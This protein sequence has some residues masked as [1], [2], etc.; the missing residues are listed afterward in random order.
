MQIQKNLIIAGLLAATV[1]YAGTQ[2]AQPQKEIETIAKPKPTAPKGKIQAAILLDVSNS[3]DGLIDQAKAQLWNMVNVMGNVTCEGEAAQI[4]IA[5]YEYGRTGND[6]NAGY[7]RQISPFTNNLDELSKKLFALDTEGGEEYCNTVVIQSLNELAWSTDTSNYKV[8]FIAGNEDYNQGKKTF[9]EACALARQKNVIVNTIYCGSKTNGVKEHWNLG[10]EC[11]KGSY[12]NID[13]GA[14]VDD[15]PTPYDSV[16]LEMNVNLNKT[17]VAYGLKGDDAME[18][19]VQVD[20]MNETKSKSMA[21]KR[22]IAKGNKSVYKNQAW[23]AVDA[24]EQDKAFFEKLNT[25]EL[26]GEL[27]GKS[28][29]EV[30]KALTEKAA[31]RSMLQ[32]QIAE[33]AVQRSK[34]LKEALAKNGKG[35][36]Q[37][38]E[39]AIEEIIRDQVQ[40]FGMVVN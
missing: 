31:Q 22:T 21:V 29:A 15:L 39:T 16:L 37:T 14:A 8:I 26:A 13:Q 36:I 4:E 2:Y 30:K 10:S 34:Y 24:A 32:K 6:Q 19:M 11:G 28:I 3:M 18:S 20:A 38:L 12:T 33:I 5:L 17:Y 7:V 9:T 25:N 23:D 1:F 35:N 27:K 40:R